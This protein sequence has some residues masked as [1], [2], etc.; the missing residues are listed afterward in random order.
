[1]ADYMYDL[2]KLAFF[3]KLVALEAGRQLVLF[4]FSLYQKNSKLFVVQFLMRYMNFPW[5]LC[6]MVDIKK[7]EVKSKG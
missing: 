2:T 7:T 5:N 3:Y 4:L 6:R 1:M